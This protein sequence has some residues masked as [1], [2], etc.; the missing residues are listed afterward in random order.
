M[1]DE[2]RARIKTEALALR[3]VFS[4]PPDDRGEAAARL[5]AAT[6]ALVLLVEAASRAM[7]DGARLELADLA[8]M[9]ERPAL[10]SEVDAVRDAGAEDFLDPAK[11]Q[12]PDKAA[13]AYRRALDDSARAGD[14][15][16]VDAARR[17]MAAAKGARTAAERRALMDDAA[18]ELFRAGHEIEGTLAEAWQA[19]REGLLG[20]QVKPEEAVMLDRGRGEWA[21]WV[22]VHLGPR[23]G[24]TPGRTLLIGGAPAGGKTSMAG[25]FAVDAMAAGCPVTVWQL[26][27]SREE[28]LEHLVAQDTSRGSRG[29]PHCNTPF[30]KRAGAPLPDAWGP[31]LTIPRWPDPTAEAVEAAIFKQARD[32]SRARR[33]GTIRHAVNG[34]VIV[35]YAQLL[36][37]ASR[38]PRDAGH[39][40]LATAASRLA[41]AAAETG[42][43][44]VL[45]SQLTKEAQR[46]TEIVASTS[47]TGADLAR[48]VHA[49][50]TI[51]R[52]CDGK[53]GLR[54]AAA[55]EKGL[56]DPIHGRARWLAW[57]KT[58]GKLSASTGLAY[59][60][61]ERAVWYRNRAWHEGPRKTNGNGN[62]AAG[63]LGNYRKD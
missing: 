25:A 12:D 15:R 62:G 58:R 2:T 9:M 3:H 57:T 7:D 63:L 53:D 23:G 55:N 52:A 16:R 27:L 37:M 28:M 61:E 35:D 49:A 10:R 31:L 20:D 59:P 33:A 48:M 26:E 29:E 19:H 43:V 38:G 21:G 13:E 6:F 45:L 36:T 42:S 51:C 24:L 47:Y 39:E 30:W 34:L 41:K 5:N 4:L 60:E 46:Q 56:D 17:M 14:M 1:N 18:H 50:V 32:T 44:L 22:N 54:A 8:A 11:G 40:I